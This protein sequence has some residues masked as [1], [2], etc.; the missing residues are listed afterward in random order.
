MA[1]VFRRPE[2]ERRI[3]ER[4]Y[5]RIAKAHEMRIRRQ[6]AGMYMAAA[7]AAE[8]GRKPTAAVKP[9]Q[10]A[11]SI[12]AVMHDSYIQFGRNTQNAIVEVTRGKKRAVQMSPEFEAGMGLYIRK[13]AGRKVT[14]V[15]DTTKARIAIIV[16]RGIDD[17]LT[18]A[19]VA[20]AIREAGLIESAYR[21]AM[22]ARTESH[23]AGNAG[24]LESATESGVV[25]AKEWISTEDERTR[26]GDNSD[27]DHTNVA[28]VPIDE[29]FI[30]SGEELMYPGDPSG[31]AGNVI[32][33]RCAIGYVV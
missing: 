14:E 30:V 2:L 25:M 24:S 20:T 23:A 8:A 29:P 6:I 7:R 26:D 11:T 17:G 27:Y 13:Y 5:I 32:N 1:K 19:E 15:T 16:Q 21:S 22:I 4:L 33:C 10:L 12:S 18:N 28:N 3:Q 9:D 31:S